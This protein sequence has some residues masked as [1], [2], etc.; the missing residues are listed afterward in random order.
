LTQTLFGESYCVLIQT[1]LRE[2][3]DDSARWASQDRMN[4]VNRALC[5]S[6]MHHHNLKGVYRPM[7]L[8]R[9]AHGAAHP[10]NPMFDTLLNRLAEDAAHLREIDDDLRDSHGRFRSPAEAAVSDGIASQE[11]GLPERP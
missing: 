5:I 11:A 6:F 8:F 10:G 1:A 9:L 2:D 4:E 7:P 3:I